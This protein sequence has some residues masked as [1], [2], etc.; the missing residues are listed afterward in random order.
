MHDA[1]VHVTEIVYVNDS[2]RNG[3]SSETVLLTVK[4]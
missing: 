3:V 1:S 4:Y 2:P